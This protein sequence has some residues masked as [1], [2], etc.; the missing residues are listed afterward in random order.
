MGEEA[1]KVYGIG[2]LETGILESLVKVLSQS[3]NGI[4]SWYV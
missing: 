1:G 4:F 3:W 2:I